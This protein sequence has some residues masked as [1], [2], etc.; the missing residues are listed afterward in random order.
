[1]GRESNPSGSEESRNNYNLNHGDYPNRSIQ[2]CRTSQPGRN[3]LSKITK[4]KRIAKATP[5]HGKESNLATVQSFTRPPYHSGDYRGILPPQH[6]K[7]SKDF[8]FIHTLC[9]TLPGCGL[10]GNR[11]RIRCLGNI[12]S[13]LLNYKTKIPY[14]HEQ[15]SPKH[16]NHSM[17]TLPQT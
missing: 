6:V 14:S 11:T 4:Q 8:L 10:V 2:N 15:G 13:I 16:I 7:R 17:G 12:R 9:F 5:F 1:M 3:N